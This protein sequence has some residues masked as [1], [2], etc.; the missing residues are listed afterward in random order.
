MIG[1]AKDL[2]TNTSTFLAGAFL[3]TPYVPKEDHMSDPERL[4]QNL[5]GAQMELTALIAGTM[6]FLKERGIP[7]SDWT[8]FIGEKFEDTWAPFEGRSPDEVM[9]HLLPLQIEPLGA[10][11]LSKNGGPQQA[12]VTLAPLPSRRV[13]EMFGTTPR[14]LLQG[15]GVT[16]KEFSA[17]YDIHKP[18]A[19]AAG[20]QFTHQSHRGQHVMTLKSA[21]N[22][23]P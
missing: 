18:A 22:R 14:E 16:Q 15:F 3:D 21:N 5:A 1:A 6:G 9:E 2:Q 19:R 8:R 17:V 12:E 20:F 4:Q 11:V 7:I 23:K 10:D 13:L